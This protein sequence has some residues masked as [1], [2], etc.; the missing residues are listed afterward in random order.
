M[1]VKYKNI[2]FDLDGVVTDSGEGIMNSVRNALNYFEIDVKDEAEL[3]RFV[4][5]PLI[6]SFSKFYGFDE[7]KAK[8]AVEKYREYYRVKGIF[9]QKIYDG[10]ER[11]LGELHKS[12]KKVFLATSKPEAFAKQILEHFNLAQNFTCISG[13]TMDLSKS[14]K[15][16]IIGD[17]IK[18][19]NLNLEETV[20]IGDRAEDIIGANE[21]HINSIGVLYGYGDYEEL[22]KVEPTYIVKDVKELMGLLVD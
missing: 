3:K 22:S 2:L 12:D 11:L 18:D 17:I 4:G 19:H 5:P 13:A 14:K 9:E 1:S 15:T 16:Q 6:T 20:M 21:N 8:L 10:I 7:E